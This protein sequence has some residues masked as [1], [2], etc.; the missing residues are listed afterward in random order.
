MTLGLSNHSVILVNSINP[1]F[2]LVVGREQLDSTACEPSSMNV[3]LFTFD[4]YV[5]FD[6]E[7]REAIDRK[8]IRAFGVVTPR[9]TV[10]YVIDL[11]AGRECRPLPP[12]LAGRLKIFPL[13]RIPIQVPHKHRYAWIADI[14]LDG[15][16]LKA[17]RGFSNGS[18][19]EFAHSVDELYAES[20]FEEVTNYLQLKAQVESMRLK[21]LRE[22][23]DLIEDIDTLPDGKKYFV[24][25]TAVQQQL[26]P[27]CFFN[28]RIN[29][30]IPTIK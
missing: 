26:Q 30:L 25:E 4:G 13:S 29:H 18:F 19:E 11:L 22:D 14:T 17:Q 8:F 28:R 12:A 9:P 1:A 2:G 16:L 21:L 27:N 15:R 6:D 23:V 20:L 7:D 3:G 24:C 5:E 10:W